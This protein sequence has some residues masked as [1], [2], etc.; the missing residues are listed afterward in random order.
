MEAIRETLASGARSCEVRA[1]AHDD[2]AARY[3]A[4]IGQLVWSHPSIRHSHFKNPAGK[5]FTL[6]PWPLD[7]Y[8]E[9]TRRVD[10][11]DYVFA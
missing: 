2:Y 4:E 9:W 7:L 10:R 11:N 3:Q 1:E 6:S 5:V 8:W